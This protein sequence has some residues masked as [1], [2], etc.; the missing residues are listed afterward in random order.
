M[1]RS[2]AGIKIEMFRSVMVL[3]L[4]RVIRWNL[5]DFCY[6]QDCRIDIITFLIDNETDS[7]RENAS[8]SYLLSARP[9]KM[10]FLLIN[11]VE[12]N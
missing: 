8:Q 6:N 3:S 2:I 1:I 4:L 7:T 11:H 10:R 9:S 12:G 5:S